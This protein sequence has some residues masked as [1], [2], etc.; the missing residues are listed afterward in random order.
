MYDHMSK[1]DYSIIGKRFGRLTVLDF[2]KMDGHVAKFLCECDCGNIKSIR[3]GNLKSGHTT[4][5]GC[6]THERRSEDLTGKRFGRL[7]VIG[8]D[9]MGTGG[10]SYWLCQCD[11]GTK[12]IVER[13]SLLSSG[14]ISCGCA[15]RDATST[16]GMTNSSLYNTWRSMKYRCDNPNHIHYDRYGG[17]GIS[18]YDEWYAFENFRD[19]AMS[20]GYSEGLTIDRIN[21]DEGYSPENC[22]WADGYTQHNNTSRNRIVTYN[23]VTHTIAEWSKLLNV[24]YSSLWGRIN[25]GDM[26]DFESYFEFKNNETEAVE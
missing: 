25:K 1:I 24:H 8:F 26:R 2:D 14:T 15:R 22:R 17:R 6:K 3:S 19:W 16:H 4:S 18:I 7:K 5:C 23:G 11:C 9:R 21:N 13:S 12:N 10:K 20:N